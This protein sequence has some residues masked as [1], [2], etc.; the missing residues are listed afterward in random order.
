VESIQQIFGVAIDSLQ[1]EV[2]NEIY[3]IDAFCER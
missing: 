1:H 3:G 2:H